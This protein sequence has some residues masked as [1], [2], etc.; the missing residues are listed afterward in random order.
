MTYRICFLFLL[1]ACVAFPNHVTGV[2]PPPDGGYPNQNTAEGEDALFSLDADA[3]Y[4]TAFG[5]H[6]NYSVVSASYDTAVGAFALSEQIFH[7]YPVN[8][9]IGSHAMVIDTSTYGSSGDG[10]RN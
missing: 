7:Y 4:H 3:A 10:G 1:L 5:Y 2:T 6:A 8:T 9:V